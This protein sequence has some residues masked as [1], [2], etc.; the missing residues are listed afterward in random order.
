MAA[1]ANCGDEWGYFS[2]AGH[3]TDVLGEKMAGSTSPYPV[4]VLPPLWDPAQW[5]M[6]LQSK[7]CTLSLEPS[8]SSQFTLAPSLLSK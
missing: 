2:P 7:P 6:P 5:A 1:K 8:P 3:M 4:F